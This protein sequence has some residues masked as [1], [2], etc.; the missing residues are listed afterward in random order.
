M[1]RQSRAV[2]VLPAA[3]VQVDILKGRGL[4]RGH[5]VHRHTRQRRAEIQI[6]RRARQHRYRGP[7][8]KGS[9][10][11]IS[12]RAP[13]GVGPI[14]QQVSGNMTDRHQIRACRHAAHRSTPRRNPWRTE[15]IA[16]AR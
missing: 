6:L 5:A 9:Q 10:R 15:A 12:G 8:P 13:D 4:R 2:Q 3:M 7:Q 1:E 11:S 16:S 14:R